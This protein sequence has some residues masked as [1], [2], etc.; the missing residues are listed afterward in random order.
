MPHEKEAHPGWD[1]FRPAPAGFLV[2]Y[3]IKG[4]VMRIPDPRSDEQRK[5]DEAKFG[6]SDFDL[7]GCDFE[8]DEKPPA[9]GDGTQTPRMRS[10]KMPDRTMQ[11]PLVGYLRRR[12]TDLWVAA[13]LGDEGQVLP[14]QQFEGYHDVIAI[15]PKVQLDLTQ[16]QIE[17]FRDLDKTYPYRW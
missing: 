4:A 7:I 13:V 6:F 1:E 10:V 12:G 3:W 5:I 2:R 16:Q 17:A 11:R 15:T 14:A 8:F 9:K